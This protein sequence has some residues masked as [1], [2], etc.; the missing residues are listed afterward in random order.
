M[1]TTFSGGESRVQDP[2]DVFQSVGPMGIGGGKA[3]E[4]NRQRPGD[5]RVRWALDGNS[6]TSGVTFREI[7]TESPEGLLVVDRGEGVQPPNRIPALLAQLAKVVQCHIWMEKVS[8]VVGDDDMST[9]FERVKEDQELRRQFIGD[10]CVVLEA[11]SAYA[12]LEDQF[13][14]LAEFGQIKNM[15]ATVAM[16]L[17]EE[18]EAFDS[19]QL[20]PS[21]GQLVD[22]F[23]G[24]ISGGDP[25]DLLDFCVEYIA[26]LELDGPKEGA[27]ELLEG[28]LAKERETLVLLAQS[29]TEEAPVGGFVR[30][31]FRDVFHVGADALE[32]FKKWYRSAAACGLPPYSFSARAVRREDSP[33]DAACPAECTV[34]CRK[35]KRGRTTVVTARGSSGSFEEGAWDLNLEVLTRVGDG[36]SFTSLVITVPFRGRVE[37]VQPVEDGVVYFIGDPLRSVAMLRYWL[38]TRGLDAYLADLWSPWDPSVTFFEKVFVDADDEDGAAGASAGD[39]GVNFLRRLVH[40]HPVTGNATDINFSELSKMAEGLDDFA[41][42]LLAADS[43]SAVRPSLMGTFLRSKSVKVVLKADRDGDEDGDGGGDDDDDD[44]DDLFTGVSKEISSTLFSLGVCKVLALCYLQHNPTWKCF[45]PEFRKKVVTMLW[46]AKGANGTGA[47][48][49]F[50]E[51]LGL[52]GGLARP[53]EFANKL[54]T[55][56]ARLGTSRSSV[57]AAQRRYLNAKADFRAK[58]GDFDD[59][60]KGVFQ[61]ANSGILVQVFS[62]VAALFKDPVAQ[63]A[64]LSELCSLCEQSDLEVPALMGE[65]P[66]MVNFPIKLKVRLELPKEEGPAGPGAGAGAGAGEGEGQRA[67]FASPGGASGTPAHGSPPPRRLLF[68]PGTPGTPGKPNLSAGVDISGEDMYLRNLVLAFHGQEGKEGGREGPMG[69]YGLAKVKTKLETVPQVTME[70]EAF[71][72][73]QLWFVTEETKTLVSVWLTWNRGAIGRGTSSTYVNG[74]WVNPSEVGEGVEWTEPLEKFCGGC[75]TLRRGPRGLGFETKVPVTVDARSVVAARFCIA[76]GGDTWKSSVQAPVGDLVKAV[77]VLTTVGLSAI[78]MEEASSYGS[79]VFNSAIR[80][81]KNDTNSDLESDGESGEAE[82]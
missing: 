48:S 43:E 17:S 8:G 62:G 36:C 51:T 34:V 3:I 69:D 30:T 59:L 67:L 72:G 40:L 47:M 41:P 35:L 9:L 26:V 22:Q 52:P 73:V 10:L 80:A 6:P 39:E 71:V 14:K 63:S 57:K 18:K 2:C 56:C 27:I 81:L 65:H 20:P 13:I 29:V 16:F 60:V 50:L 12:V 54:D 76:R 66:D 49:T 64:F 21:V 5:V 15:V 77:Q 55:L 38:E 37:A 42:F 25:S 24:V 53:V 28:I 70:A 82:A 19:S 79:R 11:A 68:S 32:G 4:C 45:T 74:S 1:G 33:T 23:K 58:Q 31:D 44:D 7:G 75:V 78:A 46:S 61:D